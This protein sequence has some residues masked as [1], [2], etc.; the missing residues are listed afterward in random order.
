[1]AS[2]NPADVTGG[3]YNRR[4]AI[5]Q[6]PA[7][8]GSPEYPHFITFTN[9]RSYTTTVQT[10]GGGRNQARRGSPGQTVALYLP[11]DALKTTY[12][13]GYGDVDM[14][15]AIGIAT[16]GANLEAAGQALAGG[17]IGAA[18]EA[19]TKILGNV[20]GS[21]LFDV[22]KKEAAAAATASFASKAGAVKQAIE[23]ASGTILNPH[24]AV[25]YNG[26]GGF[27][28]F[29]YNFSMTPKSPTEA[30]SI[31]N[32]VYFFKKHMHPS[33]GG[34]GAI[35]SVSS[36]TLKYPDEFSISYTVNKT[37]SPDADPSG[38]EP[39]FR[40]KNCFLE[41]FAVDYT[42]SSLPVFIDDDGEPQTTTI[43]MQFKETELIT[44]EDIDVGY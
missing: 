20:T 37:R 31:N 7:E 41:S 28:T 17:N 14:G 38:Q 33:V 18:G 22:V 35:S 26:P 16:S 11:P 29:S 15:A 23:R 42:T 3:N 19:V 5:Y 36:L 43:S 25:I 39:L 12:S 9:R 24:K 13:Q 10:T 34:G 21:G 40:I 2:S 27:R 4:V 44:K 6:Y 1:M 30:R 32:I 8:L